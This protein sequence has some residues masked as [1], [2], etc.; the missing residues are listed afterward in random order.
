MTPWA[1]LA[2]GVLVCCIPIAAFVVLMMHQQ[3]QDESALHDG[4]F[5]CTPSGHAY[6]IPASG[7]LYRAPQQDGLCSKG[8][9]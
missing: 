1:K 7:K 2:L 9:V 6:G 3:H 4:E 8:S 5:V